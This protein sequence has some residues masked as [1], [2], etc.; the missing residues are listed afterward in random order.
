MEERVRFT[1]LDA[2]DSP[3]TVALAQHRHGIHQ[4]VP[5]C[6][7]RVKEGPFVSAKRMGASCAVIT[8]FNTAIDF[9]VASTDFA[10]IWTKSL[11][12]PLSMSFH[13]ASPRFKRYAKHNPKTGFPGLGVQHPILPFAY[14]ECNIV[15]FREISRV[16]TALYM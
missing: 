2:A 6:A 8:P 7:Q 16:Y 1:M 11:I 4:H 10:N 9:D 15:I 12:A 13:N 3:E 5:L 14:F